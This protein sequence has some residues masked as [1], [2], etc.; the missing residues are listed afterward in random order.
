MSLVSS[1][2]TTLDEA[3]AAARRI[4]GHV[5][6][7]SLIP[8][9]ALS[10]RLGV[11]VWLKRELDQPTGSFKVRGVFNAALSM[12]ETML[13]RGLAA[14]SA[15]NHAAAV[16]HVGAT[17]GVP[18]TVCMP[19]R[20]VPVKIEATR[21]LGAEVILVEQDLVGTTQRLAAERGLTLLHPFDDGAIVAGHA[22]VGLELVAESPQVDLVVVPVGGGGLISGVAAAVKQ[23]RPATRVVGV[24]PEGADV[25]FRS[26]AAG[27]PESQPAPHSIA[28]GLTAPITGDIP[29]AHIRSFVDSIVRVP[30]SIILTALS[31]LI[32]EERVLAEPAAAAAVAGM[33]WHAVRAHP[34]ARVVF[35]LSGGNVSPDLVEQV[36]A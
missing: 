33:L 8:A 29:L 20:A 6:R 25:V 14:F 23:L 24:E 36:S 13:R 12:S 4:D 27:R 28:D 35:I 1:P 34:G 9:P 7:T 11:D 16:A 3:R 22:G 26:L 5:R 31:I 10:D 17:L 30:D 32:R 19:A 21:A 15:G 18:V 2:L